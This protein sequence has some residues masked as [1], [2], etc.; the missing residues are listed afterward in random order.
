MEG[1]AL[2]PVR[3][4][5]TTGQHGNDGWTRTSNLRGPGLGEPDP[6]AARL[7]YRC[8]DSYLEDGWGAKGDQVAHVA[9]VA[10]VSGP[11]TSGSVSA[12]VLVVLDFFFPFL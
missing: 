3:V 1:K 2:L 5:K 10:L 8:A 6:L 11:Q 7:S 9:H 12:A 4:V